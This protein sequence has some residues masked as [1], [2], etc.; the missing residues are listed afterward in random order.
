MGLLLMYGVLARVLF[1]TAPFHG[2]GQLVGWSFL[3]GVPFAIGML[4]VAIARWNGSDRWIYSGVGIPWIVTG[5][6]CVASMLARIEAPI[7]IL[8][9]S[10]FLLG[11]NFI[12][13]AYRQF[14]PSQK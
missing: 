6:G 8:M 11:A 12:G 10:P 1:N 2:S 13:A 3:F 7:C 14:H 4:G 9:A 5:I